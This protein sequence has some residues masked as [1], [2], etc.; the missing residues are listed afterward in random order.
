MSAPSFTCY[1]EFASIVNANISY[2]TNSTGTYKHN[3]DTN[4]LRSSTNNLSL[5]LGT[6]TVDKTTIVNQQETV[7]GQWQFYFNFVD[8]VLDIP[9]GLLTVNVPSVNCIPVNEV[10]EESDP[11][12]DFTKSNID[13]Y[14]AG[15]YKGIVSTPQ[16]TNIYT[17]SNLS[18]SFVNLIPVYEND[19]L[20]LQ[21][22]FY[23]ELSPMN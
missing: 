2:W 18:T 17:A 16:C 21:F 5:G 4:S 8:N 11:I 22:D 1:V 3:I 15:Q 23:L 6:L 9:S 7:I 20:F 14:P 13:I 19:I 12:L 10:I